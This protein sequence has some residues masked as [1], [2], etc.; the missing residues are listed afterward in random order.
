MSMN[1][2]IACRTCPHYKFESGPSDHSPP[3]YGVMYCELLHGDHGA[4]TAAE[5]IEIDM[6]DR[7]DNC[8]LA[9][10]EFTKEDWLVALCAWNNVPCDNAAMTKY[11]DEKWGRLSVEGWKRVAKALREHWKEEKA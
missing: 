9:A 10:G 8:P 11:A 4:F 6:A 7:P 3:S 1:N 2:S 5:H